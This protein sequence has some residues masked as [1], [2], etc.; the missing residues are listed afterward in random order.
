MSRHVA[1]TKDNLQLTVGWDPPMGTYFAQ[2]HRTDAP[3][4]EE[5]L[6]AWIGYEMRSV[7]DVEQLASW[8]AD[9]GFALDE[10]VV[11]Q[12]QED[13]AEPWEPGPLQRA[14]GFTGEADA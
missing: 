10:R 4:D 6:V 11:I 1:G 5:D 2:V 8:C 3:L 9:R 12:L 14:L 13:R 7:T